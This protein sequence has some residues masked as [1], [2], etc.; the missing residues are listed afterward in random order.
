MEATF[1]MHDHCVVL[2]SSGS[3]KVLQPTQMRFAGHQI[4]GRPLH[5]MQ[6]GCETKFPVCQLE[7]TP[8][9][10]LFMYGMLRAC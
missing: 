4:F 1:G 8:C 2:I 6:S 10:S 9:A 5:G 7:S 3:A